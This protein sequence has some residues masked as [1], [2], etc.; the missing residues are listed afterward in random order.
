[1]SALITSLGISIHAPLTGSDRGCPCFFLEVV[2]ISIH[3]PLTGSDST[4]ALITAI[5]RNFNPRSPY[6][7][8]LVD[9][10][11]MIWDNRFQSTLPLRGA[12]NN[13]QQP[14]QNQTISIHAP[15]TGSDPVRM[16]ETSPNR[17]FNPRSPYGERLQLITC[18]AIQFGFQST[19]PLRGATWTNVGPPA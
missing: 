1:M 6:G 19:L 15:L 7:E 17:N 2:M 12:T 5:G 13:P 9:E 4:G 16:L 8:R 14:Y 3:A 18:K 11:G 10:V